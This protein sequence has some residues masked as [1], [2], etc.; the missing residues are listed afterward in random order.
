LTISKFEDDINTLAANLWDAAT[1]RLLQTLSGRSG[2][3]NTTAFSP[4]GRRIVT[5]LWDKTARLWNVT[6]AYETAPKHDPRPMA[7]NSMITQINS[8]SQGVMIGADYD[9]IVGPTC[10]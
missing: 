2:P 8:R 6:P 1:G 9:P 10:S 5:G 3:I 4:D 7:A